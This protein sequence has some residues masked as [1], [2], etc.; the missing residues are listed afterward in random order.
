[1][2]WASAI[3]VISRG[4][5]ETLPAQSDHLYRSACC[6]RATSAP[7]CSASSRR[8]MRGP[9]QWRAWYRHDSVP[10][11]Q[12][13]KRRLSQIGK[14][15]NT[16]YASTDFTTP[17]P[18]SGDINVV[19]DRASQ[20][21]MD[22]RWLIHSPRRRANRGDAERLLGLE[23]DHQLGLRRLLNGQVHPY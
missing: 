6:V 20:S 16:S 10:K 21:R 5:L 3:S 14:R 17:E 11:G 15:G 4:K 1:M 2:T 19:N 9:I 12:S 18:D 23:V 7:S 22:L 8:L 13:R